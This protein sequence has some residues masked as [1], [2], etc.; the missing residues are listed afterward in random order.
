ML[1]V[2]KGKDKAKEKRKRVKKTDLS[3]SI[4]RPI[5]NRKEKNIDERV[6]EDHEGC[7]STQQQKLNHSN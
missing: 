2:K 5:N 7:S 3:R 4:I 1:K 6:D